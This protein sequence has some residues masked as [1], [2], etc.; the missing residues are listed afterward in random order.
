MTRNGLLD[1]LRTLFQGSPVAPTVNGTSLPIAE[2]SPSS[3]SAVTELALMREAFAQLEH[4]ILLI[5]PQLRLHDWNPAAAVLLRGTLAPG[6]RLADVA[7]T[8]DLVSLCDRVRLSGHP[9][10]QEFR[11]GSDQ[12]QVFEATARPLTLDDG[13]WLLATFVDR[14]ASAAFHELRREFVTNVTHELKTPLTNIAG[15]AETLINGAAAIPED[16]QRF[17]EIIQRNSEQL[18][19]LIEDLLTIAR[20]EEAVGETSVETCD[21]RTVRDL[22]LSDLASSAEVAHVH[23]VTEPLTEPWPLPLAATDLYALLKNLVENAIRYN[24]PGG[25]VTFHEESTPAAFTIAIIDTGEGISP[26]DLP[27]IFER[28]YR[29]DK[30]RSRARGGTGLG[31]AIV[32]N[33]VERHGGTVTVQSIQGQGSTFTVELPRFAHD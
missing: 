4:P 5:D 2:V 19:A 26:A 7:G 15:A 3:T 21:Y 13:V 28:F 11:L 18:R 27:R 33:L 30:Q 32:K 14:T 20:S 24:K 12:S 8:F 23:F 17:L 22:I 9:V 16:R 6:V 31:L 1:T 10:R 29:A 25:T